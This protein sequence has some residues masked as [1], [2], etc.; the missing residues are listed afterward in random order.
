MVATGVA[1]KND[2]ISHSELYEYITSLDCTWTSKTVKALIAPGLCVLVIL[3]LPFLIQNTIV[4]DHAA[5]SCIDKTT[6]YNLL[7]PLPVSPPAPPKPRLCEQLKETKANK[8]LALAE[9]LM[10]CNDH[11]KEDFNIAGAI[12]DYIEI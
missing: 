3:G 7:D 11:F 1:L 5:H 8:K 6:N 12:Q 10:V 2:Q 4:T 9:L